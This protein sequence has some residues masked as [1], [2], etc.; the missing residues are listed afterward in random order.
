MFGRAIGGGVFLFV[1]RNGVSGD[2]LGEQIRIG[3]YETNID[4]CIVRKKDL[5]FWLCAIDHRPGIVTTQFDFYKA[6]LASR[7]KA[8]SHTASNC[9]KVI[10]S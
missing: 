7:N 4:I 2:M 5:L 10:L 9:Q 6:L 3:N 1:S 8:I